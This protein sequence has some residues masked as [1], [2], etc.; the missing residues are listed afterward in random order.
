MYGSCQS[1]AVAQSTRPATRSGCA[2][3]QRPDRAAHRVP[4]GHD[5]LR[6][7]LADD[8]GGVVGA[9]GQPEA[10]GAAQPAAVTAVV[11]REDTVAGAGE[12][13]V[14]RDPVEVRGHHPAVEEQERGAVAAG[15]A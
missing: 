7:L 10:L 15:V 8:R 1:G 4:D 3:E 2:R 13:V 12:H 5:A 6:A 9:G 11:E 14:D